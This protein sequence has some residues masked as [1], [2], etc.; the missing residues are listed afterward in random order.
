MNRPIHLYTGLKL[1]VA[2]ICILLTG[3]GRAKPLATEL[4]LRGF[5]VIPTPQRVRLSSGDVEFG[6]GWSYDSRV[7]A[8]HSAPR[9]LLKDLQ[10]FYSLDLRKADPASKNV[11]ALSI[12]SETVN[13]GA[14]KEISRQAYQLKITPTRIDIIGNDDPGLFYG[15]QT[16][17]QLLRRG[18]RGNLLLPVCTIEDW[19]SSQLRFLHWDTKHHQDR[20]ETLKRYL[21]WSARFKINMIGFELEDKFEY[22]SNPIIGAPG[23][24]TTAQLQ[25]IVNYG[26]DR[27]IQVVPQIQSPAHMAYVLKHPEYADL[28]SDGNNYQ[29][30]LCDERSDKLIFSMYDDV[31]K[32]TQGVQYFHVSTDEVYYAGI[33]AKCARP[34]NPENRSLAWVEFANRAHKFLQIRNR[35]MLAWVEYPVLAKH[36]PLLPPGLINGVM[37]GEADQLQ[38]ERKLGMRDLIYTSMQG[39]ELLFPDNLAAE[40]PRGLVQGRLEA[41]FEAL[42]GNVRQENPVGVYGA[43]W[44]DSGLHSETFW[45]GWS[46]VAQYGW[47][48]GIPSVEQHV[49]EFMNFYYGP[50]V[51][52]MT[53]VYRGM[54]AQA[55]FFDR[56]WD[57]VE[58]RVRGKA[59]G[60]SE[61]KG[62]GGTRY[63]RTLP[64]PA[65]PTLPALD[66]K[67]IYTGRYGKLVD[68][69]R[70]MALEDDILQ[71]RLYENLAKADRNRYNLE[72]FLSLAEFTG[73]Y[74]RMLLG[75]KSIEDALAAA[76]GAAA[77]DNPRAALRQL[78]SAR[79]Q[80]LGLIQDRH[81]TFDFLRNIWEK[82][83]FPKGLEVNGRK[84]LHV[85]DDTKDHWAD[86]RSDLTY[87]TAPEESIGLDKW[88]QQLEAIT[89]EY[90]KTHG[91]A[92]PG[93]QE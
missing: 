77:N 12:L 87:M 21:D 43:A 9:S 11:V 1:S 38:A 71:H 72:V 15:V 62:I 92:P 17:L 14:D 26:L 53:D 79:S 88:V 56:S 65:L 78:S 46:V 91:I 42:S 3:T 75:M 89:K 59:Y 47:K 49:A 8:R 20:I 66:V 84:F 67:P 57:R 24:F 83:R 19:P 61:G 76:Q 22:P 90:A 45:L 80:A 27:H 58:S 85:M 39:D 31:I 82:S 37:P 10:D 63:D 52:G 81:V 18:T 60:N 33:C 34:Y 2:L 74:N 7:T 30:C 23:A 28:R 93:T 69:A 50:N 6:E 44:D 40:G 55:R 36:I 54:Q 64:A 70:S 32:A 73:H 5:S 86:R 51:S 29:T 4:F 25:E 35:K 68:Q 16:F 13:T 48:P 41:A